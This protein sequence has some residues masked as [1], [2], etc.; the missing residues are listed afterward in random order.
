MEGREAFTG[1]FINDLDDA[2]F[3]VAEDNF[4]LLENGEFIL[5]EDNQRII[6]E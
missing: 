2:G 6:L 5:L 1:L 4:L 3:E